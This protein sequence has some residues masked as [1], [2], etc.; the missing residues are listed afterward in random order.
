MIYLTK[1][2]LNIRMNYKF[3]GVIDLMKN[4]P[5]LFMENVCDGIRSFVRM[6]ILHN[7]E[8]G[9]FIF[10]PIKRRIKRVIRETLH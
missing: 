1:I 6:K 4:D 5:D 8:V 9:A 3:S 7:D 10:H 2:D